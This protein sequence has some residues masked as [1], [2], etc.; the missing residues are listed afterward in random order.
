[1]RVPDTP[2]GLTTRRAIDQIVAIEVGPNA[3][4]TPI[5]HFN[6]SKGEKFKG[7]R[8]GADGPITTCVRN[9]VDHPAEWCYLYTK[10]ELG[11]T[12]GSARAAMQSFTEASRALI[13]DATW[14][15]EERRVDTP[16]PS[17]RGDDYVRRQGAMFEKLGVE[18]EDLDLTDFLEGKAKVD[19]E[20]VEKEKI[21]RDNTIPEDGQARK[22]GASGA[23]ARTDASGV[24][25]VASS[26]KSTSSFNLRDNYCQS[27]IANG[28]QKALLA[29]MQALMADKG[30]GDDF[31]Q[32]MKGM[33]GDAMNV[34]DVS[35]DEEE[36]PE[37]SVN[38][39]GAKATK[40]RFT[41]DEDEVENMH[42]DSGASSVER[43]APEGD[44]RS[45][46]IQREP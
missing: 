2:E 38:G 3:G 31:D 12:E 40:P 13:D 37:N 9:L 15:P 18:Y 45:Q 6:D 20:D 24:S 5:V 4:G 17:E 43:P 29:A 39:E 14:I 46:G 42:N 22:V 36:E 30:L 26:A 44:G 10:H 23:S 28:K 32:I 21:M 27:K 11:Y 16:F 25:S 41:I 1:M 33:E 19:A 34:N 7:K 8:R 35:S